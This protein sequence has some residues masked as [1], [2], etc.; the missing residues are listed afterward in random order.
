MEPVL[1]ALK[2]HWTQD[3]AWPSTTIITVERFAGYSAITVTTGSSVATE[4]PV[5]FE[6]WLHT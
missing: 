2:Q 4:T 1:S 5:Y 6:Q 3:E